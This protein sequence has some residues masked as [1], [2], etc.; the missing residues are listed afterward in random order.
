M[1]VVRLGVAARL[2]GAVHE[3][4]EGSLSTSSLGGMSMSMNMSSKG[5][6]RRSSGLAELLSS[7]KTIEMAL[8][9][10]KEAEEEEKEQE[11]EARRR[12]QV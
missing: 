5:S 2:G 4:L 3:T 10:K 12:G 8:A 6:R 9:E 11:E 1:T 7:G